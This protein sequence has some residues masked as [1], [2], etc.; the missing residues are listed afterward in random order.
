[1]TPSHFP[2][3]LSPS[4]WEDKYCF[5][6]TIITVGALVVVVVIVV[7]TVLPAERKTQYSNKVLP[8]NIPHV[9]PFNLCLLI[10]LRQVK[11]LL[12]KVGGRKQDL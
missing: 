7:K 8:I 1:M 5:T 9:F 3:T 10:L 12:P 2:I 4:P 6:V 11:E